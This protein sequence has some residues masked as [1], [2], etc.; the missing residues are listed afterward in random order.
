MLKQLYS[1]LLSSGFDPLGILLLPSNLLRFICSLCKYS[2]LRSGS[3]FQA[4]KSIPMVALYPVINEH[5]QRVGSSSAHYFNQ[6]ILVARDIIKKNPGLHV[7]VGSRIDSFV[8]H[9]LSSDLEVLVGDIRKVD[10]D[11]DKL[12][13]FQFDL[14]RERGF[15]NHC[16]KYKSVSCLHA[17]EHM[18]LGRYGD[19]LDKD[20]HIKALI[21]LR[22]LLDLDG[23]LYLSH[24]FGQRL[25]IEFNAHR[26]FTLEYMRLLFNSLDLV[27]I[28][29]KYICDQGLI[30]YPSIE[31]IDYTS[32]YDQNYACAVW[33]LRNC[34]T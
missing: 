5:Y 34:S 6:D 25:R 2:L 23:I 19:K 26:V 21:N 12:T 9:L 29:F 1:L 20:G 8:G 16:A 31:A 11:I 22:D 18:G 24:P 3:R 13:T 17:I 28:D 32:S 15:G 4:H 10:Y 30:H 33:Q 7:D 14:M 27:V